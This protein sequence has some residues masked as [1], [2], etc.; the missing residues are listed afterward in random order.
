MSY[1]DFRNNKI[2]R[3]MKTLRKAHRAVY[4]R[5][6]HLLMGFEDR[7]IWEVPS[8]FEDVTSELFSRYDSMEYTYF[9]SIRKWRE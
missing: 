9:G 1:F 2:A 8:S 4:W 6:Y 5:S 3:R 7:Q